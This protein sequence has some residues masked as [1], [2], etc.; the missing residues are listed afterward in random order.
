MNEVIQ[1]QPDTARTIERLWALQ[2]MN[3][4][5]L[6]YYAALTLDSDPIL[7]VGGAN[8]LLEQETIPDLALDRI[9][10]L[11]VHQ[12]VQLRAFDYFL[13][14][15]DHARARRVLDTPIEETPA[16]IK[17]LLTATYFQDFD[18]LYEVEIAGFYRT[19]TPESLAKAALAAE[20]RR[21]RCWYR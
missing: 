4:G 2:K 11:S 21:C 3:L 19:G 6:G 12:S 20:R 5:P 9:I 1:V 17:R 13:E 18:V 15:Y 7:A 8:I 16:I 10:E 14:R